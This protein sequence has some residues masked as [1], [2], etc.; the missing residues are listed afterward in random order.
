MALSIWIPLVTAPLHP[1]F[2]TRCKFNHIIPAISLANMAVFAWWPHHS[3]SSSDWLQLRASLANPYL[4]VS[5]SLD[6]SAAVSS[7]S[8]SPEGM[9]YP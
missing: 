4:G 3:L 5:A 2:F 1:S 6:R 8:I 9:G 7:L